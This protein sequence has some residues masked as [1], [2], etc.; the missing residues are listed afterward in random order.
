MKNKN[1]QKN[2]QDSTNE[3]WNNNDKGW[4]LREKKYKISFNK[5]H[6]KNVSEVM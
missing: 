6:S 2:L 4:N 3:Q 5:S 1:N